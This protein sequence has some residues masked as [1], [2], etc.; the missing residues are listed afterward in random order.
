MHYH[1]EEII[2]HISTDNASMKK[3]GTLSNG[4]ECIINK[5]AT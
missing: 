1:N 3:F 4:G 2:M 5:I